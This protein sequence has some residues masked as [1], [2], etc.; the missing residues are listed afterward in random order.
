MTFT[1]QATNSISPGAGGTAGRT[2]TSPQGAG[3]QPGSHRIDACYG[4]AASLATLGATSTLLPA[5][6]MAHP[7]GR[8]LY[9]HPP[10]PQ[11]PNR[12]QVGEYAGLNIRAEDSYVVA[13]SSLLLTK[14]V[15][16]LVVPLAQVGRLGQP[17]KNTFLLKRFS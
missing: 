7:G 2:R 12:T 5:K 17:P 14:R 10:G 8:Q 1:M 16:L 11:I 3:K 9:F 4:G 6:L 15:R 13:P